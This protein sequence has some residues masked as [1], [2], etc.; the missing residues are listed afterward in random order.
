MSKNL[1]QGYAHVIYPESCPIDNIYEFIV[2]KYPVA[3]SPLHDKDLNANGDPKKPHYHLLFNARLSQK[4][5]AYISRITTMM[6]FET[7]YS[8]DGYFHYLFHW[9]AKKGCY[10][11]GKAQYKRDDIFMSDTFSLDDVK[12]E[13]DLF[14]EL[15]LCLREHDLN[16]FA[17]LTDFLASLDDDEMLKYFIKHFYLFERYLNSLNKPI[18]K[19]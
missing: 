8:L 14:R 3:I 13:R 9:D 7:V 5:R 18:D 6:Y 2:P 10:I 12:P 16:N 4:D 11:D 19:K 1:I 15:L 17:Q